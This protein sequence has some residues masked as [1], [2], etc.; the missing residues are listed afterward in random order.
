MRANADADRVRALVRELARALTTSSPRSQA[1]ESGA[2][3]ER[4]AELFEQIEP[5]LFRYPAIKAREFRAKLD[6]VLGRE[7]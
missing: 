7:S 3:S 1:G 2:H 4:L 6:R 5:E